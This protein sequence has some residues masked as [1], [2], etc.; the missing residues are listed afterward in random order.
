MLYIILKGYTSQ[1]DV[2]FTEVNQQ[3]HSRYVPR[4]VQIDLENGVCSHVRVLW[5][6]QG[7]KV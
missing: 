4:S 6:P 5:I 3:G 2:F 1:V 7:R